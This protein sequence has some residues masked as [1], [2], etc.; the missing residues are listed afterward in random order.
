MVQRREERRPGYVWGYRSVSAFFCLIW[1][2]RLVA[3]G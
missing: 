1:R 2:G 3:Y